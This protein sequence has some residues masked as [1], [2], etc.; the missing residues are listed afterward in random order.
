M[1]YSV[2]RTFSRAVF[3]SCITSSG[4]DRP[5]ANWRFKVL[6]TAWLISSSITL[7][8]DPVSDISLEFLT[9]QHFFSPFLFLPVSGRLAFS[10]YTL[11][12]L[13]GVAAFSFLDCHSY[14][15]RNIELLFTGSTSDIPLGRRDIH[16]KQSW[17]NLET[18]S[19]K[20]Y[21]PLTIVHVILDD[22][23]SY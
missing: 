10:S 20:F 19:M 23:V 22:I 1:T 2:W 14:W 21:S 3:C 12:F 4:F 13:R 5:P 16:S 18:D 9:R 11:D 15:F 8:I 6:S 7:Q 17:W